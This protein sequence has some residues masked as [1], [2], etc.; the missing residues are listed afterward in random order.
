MGYVHLLTTATI[1]SLRS[2]AP[3][4][5]FEI[6]RFRPNFVLE[7]GERANGF[8]E[9]DWVGRTLSLGREVRL[10]ILQTTP[11]CVMTTLSQGDLP[12]DPGVLRATAQHNNGDVGVYAAVVQ[13][14]RVR[15]ADSI[16]LE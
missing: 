9:N 2:H 7:L 3:Q 8:V 16:G 13:G 5:R 12:K 10:R 1:E 14:G 4:S 15:R 6:R 11:R